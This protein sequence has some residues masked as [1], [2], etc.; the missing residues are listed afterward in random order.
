MCYNGGLLGTDTVVDKKTIVFFVD[1]PLAGVAFDEENVKLK[2]YKDIIYA[3]DYITEIYDADDIGLAKVLI[4]YAKNATNIDYFGSKVAIVEKVSTIYDEEIG[5]VATTISLIVERNGRSILKI[6]K[7]TT[8]TVKMPKVAYSH[9]DDIAKAEELQAGDIIQFEPRG[10][11]LLS[12]YPLYLVR[13]PLNNG[14]YAACDDEPMPRMSMVYS[15]V[16]RRSGYI[17]KLHYGVSPKLFIVNNDVVYY[18]Y[19]SVQKKLYPYN[20]ADIIDEKTVGGAELASKVVV[21]KRA[22]SPLIMMKIKDNN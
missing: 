19:D 20:I 17:L 7:N 3:T 4:V 14:T 9:H 6:D 2:S 21:V 5:E 1:E 8:K 10:E 11:F 16:M 12:W 13:Y 15:S 22:N 18:E